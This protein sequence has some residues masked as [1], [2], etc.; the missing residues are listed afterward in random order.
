M[1]SQS[2]VETLAPTGFVSTPQKQTSMFFRKLSLP[3]FLRY[4]SRAARPAPQ[5]FATTPAA[6]GLRVPSPLRLTT[7]PLRLLPGIWPTSI[8]SG[9]SCRWLRRARELRSCEPSRGLSIRRAM[10]KFVCSPL[11]VCVAIICISTKVSLSLPHNLGAR[12]LVKVPRNQALSVKH[13]ARICAIYAHQN[14]WE[15][16][17]ATPEHFEFASSIVLP[18]SAYLFMGPGR[19]RHRKSLSC[20]SCICM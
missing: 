2:L 8:Q 17:V 19:W 5:S 4:P 1:S 3:V 11:P 12:G 9:R 15:R 20:I 13:T 14:K 16:R 6:R 7:T 18:F 10:A